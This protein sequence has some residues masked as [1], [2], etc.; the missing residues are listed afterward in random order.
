MKNRI[1]L[2]THLPNLQTLNK[3]K[4]V[5]IK[6][7]RCDFNWDIIEPHQ[8][9][10]DYTIIDQI[11]NFCK[12]NDVNVFPTIGYTPGWANGNRSHNFPPNNENDWT[13]FVSK[14]VRRYKDDINIWSI[15]NEP[16]TEYF[17]GT[18]DEYIQRIFVPASKIIKSLGLKVATPEISVTDPKWW[19]WL[20]RFS[21]LRDKYDIMT[22]H[23]YAKDGQR[24]IDYIENSRWPW[25]LRWLSW[26]LNRLYPVYQ[27]I[28][29]KLI[30]ESWLTETGW[31]TNGTSEVKQRQNYEE[32][33]A[34][35]RSHSTLQKVFF[36]EI[37]DDPAT[38]FKFGVLRSDYSAKPA[39]D[40]IKSVCQ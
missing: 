12:D 24:V 7:I 4:E 9:N 14:V 37:I 15:W 39:Y 8:G 36:Y 30:G 35:L 1:G 23:C 16:N 18:L 11:V 5:N 10:F 29:N 3:I 38:P 22:F 25:Y 19:K 20:D 34:Y 40:Y 28:K 31:A 26:F 33:V 27:P 21:T 17:Q 2:N 32:I 13:N 6:W